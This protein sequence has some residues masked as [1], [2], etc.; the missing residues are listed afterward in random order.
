MGEGH[1]ARICVKTRRTLAQTLQPEQ[2]PESSFQT[3][4]VQVIL[5]RGVPNLQQNRQLHGSAASFG[6]VS[7]E[8]FD[9]QIRKTSSGGI[10]AV[11]GIQNQIS[12]IP[13]VRGVTLP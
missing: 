13:L 1:S 9:E 7:H 5:I 2:S 4:S 10:N 11:Q 6:E 8:K 3:S 12:E